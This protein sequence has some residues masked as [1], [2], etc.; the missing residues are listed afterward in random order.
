M[1]GP[2]FV[3]IIIFFFFSK[4]ENCFRKL[5]VFLTRKPVAVTRRNELA[6]EIDICISGV[7]CFIFFFV[8]RSV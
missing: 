5:V 7:L 4:N 1:R 6:A 8:L 2:V 3:F